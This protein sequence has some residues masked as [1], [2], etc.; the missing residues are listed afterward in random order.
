MQKL[1]W[2]LERRVKSVSRKKIV[3]IIVEGPSDDEA[4][5]VLLNRLYHENAVH[6]EIVHGDITSEKSVTPKNIATKIGN[7]VRGY[8]ASNHYKASDFQ[9][10]IHLVDTD[11]A[12]ISKKFIAEQKGIHQPFYT[13]TEIQTAKPEQIIERNQRKSENLNR[14]CFMNRVWKTL[15]YSVYYMSVNLD[16]VLYNKPNST[17]EEKE[18]NAYL[19]AKKYKDNLAD[20]L[21]FLSDSDFSVCQ[22]YRQSWEYIQEGIHSLER[23]TNLG[24]C[25]KERKH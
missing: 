3:F 6:I 17:D 21:S 22:D 5:G 15:P 13:E 12:Y 14:I 11:G 1:L 16:H 10:V 23:H 9:E 19:F 25:F 2:H 4:L 18:T 7:L 24:I 20:F 8:A